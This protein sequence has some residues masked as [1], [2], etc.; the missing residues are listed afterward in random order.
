MMLRRR[1]LGV[2]L[3][4]I[5]LLLMATG[6]PAASVPV[7]VL[8]PASFAD[9]SAGLV[10][11]FNATHPHI[12]LEVTRGPL[13]TESVSDLAIS[14]LLL[15]SSP[16][17]LL[18]MDVTWTPKY[19]AAGW[20]EPLEEWIGEDALAPLAPGADLGNAFA[21]HLWRF[22]MVASMGLLYWRT[23]LM[24]APPRTPT[25]LEQISRQLQASGAVPWGYVWQG[26]QYEGLST[27]FLEMLRGFGGRW[28]VDGSPQLDSPQAIAAGKVGFTTM[29]AAPGEPHVATQGSWGLA[30]TKDSPHKRAAIEAL[31]FLT[32]QESQ[33][34]LYEEF[35]YTPTRQAVF[36]DPA[37]VAS[38]PELPEL[39][40]ALADAALR[41]L[42][43]VYAQIS[44]LLY[45]EL[46]RVFTGRINPEQGMAQ[47]QEQT[48]QLKRTVGGEL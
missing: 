26:R 47:L 42:T 38:H 35:G 3:A 29:V 32:S 6:V 9:A 8:M 25:E 20:L 40:E 10:R 45:R 15:G 23:D 27:V 28:I 44:D 13:D 41:P 36:Q 19:V 21:G 43:P 30:L 39:E 14:S 5:T 46:S 16:Y 11:E 18:L 34:R 12:R 2:L 4:S 33:T 1:L 24:T 22:P 7:S 17:D 37:L 48:L 31:Q